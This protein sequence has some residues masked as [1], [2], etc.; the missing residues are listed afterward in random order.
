MVSSRGDALEILRGGPHPDAS[1][2]ASGHAH[3]VVDNCVAPPRPQSIVPWNGGGR[4]STSH[5]PLLAVLL[6]TSSSRGSHVAFRWPRKPRVLKRHS[7]VRYY[8]AEE[9]EEELHFSKP[10][11]HDQDILLPRGHRNQAFSTVQDKATAV[12]AA[13]LPRQGRRETLGRLGVN[14]LDAALTVSEVDFEQHHEHLG[15]FWSDDQGSITSPSESS[16]SSS[17]N[18]AETGSGEEKTAVG[19]LGASLRVSISGPGLA[20][21][22]GSASAVRRYSRSTPAQT[23]S[24]HPAASNRPR[25]EVEQDSRRESDAGGSDVGG[26]SSV[27]NT[28]DEERP[29]SRERDRDRERNIRAHKMYLGYECDFLAS[30]LSPKQDL[31]HQKFEMVI[32]DLAFVGHPVSLDHSEMDAA[33]DEF[34]QRGRKEGRRADDFGAPQEHSSGACEGRLPKTKLDLF[35]LVLVVDRPDPSAGT[36]VL[37]LTSY[38]QFFYDNVVF[39]MT[40]ALYAEQLRVNYI[41]EE[42]EKL[43]ALRERCI[44]DGQSLSAYTAQCLGMSSLASSIRDLYGSLSASS[45]AFVTIND[46]IEVHLQLPPI[47]RSSAQLLKLPDVETDIDP[48]DPLFLSGG[49]FAGL[50]RDPASLA[51]FMDLEPD[52]LLYEEWTRT[53]GAYLLPWKTL[54]LMNDWHDDNDVDLPPGPFRYEPEHGKNRSPDGVGLEPW[55]RK[56]TRLL[57]PTLAGIPTFAELADLLGWDLYEDVYP[58]ARHLIY[59]GEAKVVDVPRLKSM[60]ANSPLLELSDLPELSIIWAQTF[61]ELAPL[62]A[63]LASLSQTVQ[64][65]S[66]LPDFQDGSVSKATSLQALIW[67][68]REDVIVHMHVRL[69]LIARSEIKVKW[70]QQKQEADEE[71]RKA[72]QNKEQSSVAENRGDSGRKIRKEPSGESSDSVHA[73]RGR[74]RARSRSVDASPD[75]FQ[76]PGS[77][78]AITETL[79]KSGTG[80]GKLPDEALRFER[81]AVLRSRSPSNLISELQLGDVSKE[82]GVRGRRRYMQD[83]EKVAVGSYGTVFSEP[84]M[85]DRT[86]VGRPARALSRKGRSPSRARKTIKGFGEGEQVAY[87]EAEM[88]PTPQENKGDRTSPLLKLRERNGKEPLLEEQEDGSVSAV[89]DDSDDEWVSASTEATLIGEP[90]RASRQENEWIAVMAEDKE[91]WLSQRFNRLLPYLNGKHTLDEIAYR[92]EMRRRELKIVLEAFRADIITFLHP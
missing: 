51:R 61:T 28:N 22:M 53:T 6:V 20:A 15:A 87:D 59:Y 34:E 82:A 3:P 19:S 78:V 37:D 88:S 57:Q 52:D 21:S 24:K 18:E 9:E 46:S 50:G 89:E 80:D 8:A 1:P 36:A 54:L 77:C 32:D 83:P 23:R 58:M 16:I 2:S 12:R 90:S 81:R 92:E 76:T 27:P 64:P 14:G 79:S 85:R 70:K 69:R 66:K 74:T 17:S 35:H 60:Y 7:R 49:G 11:S 39:K 25:W 63:F 41:S 30:L 48:L 31:C 33:E 72:K 10:D 68:L 26:G 29:A 65:Y 86:P 84:A 4:S 73:V 45:D 13:D 5:S 62:P 40:A 43:V 55:A 75:R 56:F 38:L 71:R 91:P 67:L 42:A 47:L 44:D